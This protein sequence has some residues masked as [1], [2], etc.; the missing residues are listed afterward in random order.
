VLLQLFLLH[1]SC[2]YV[3]FF[4][5]RVIITSITRKT[6]TVQEELG[7]IDKE[8]RGDSKTSL[9]RAL[10]IPEGIIRSW[11]KEDKVLDCFSEVMNWMERQSDCV[12]LH[13]LHLQYITTYVAKKLHQ[14]SRQKKKSDFK[15]H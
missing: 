11:T 15:I 7:I 2:N 4:N 10:D 8:N 9:F 3:I 5:F 6:Y 14:L 12:H 1:P 13:L